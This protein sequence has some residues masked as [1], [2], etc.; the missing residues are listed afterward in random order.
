[1]DGRAAGS[2]GCAR[3]GELERQLAGMKAQLAALEAQVAAATKTSATSSKPPS[4]DIVKPKPK[5]KRSKRRRGAQSGHPKHDRPSFEPKQITRI[6]EHDLDACPQ[7]GG[8]LE[9]I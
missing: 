7:C 5:R 9:V 4:S 6:E 8:T 3:C 1:M 2:D